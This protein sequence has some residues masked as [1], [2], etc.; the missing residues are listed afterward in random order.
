MEF[1][2]FNESEKSEWNLF[3]DS[4]PYAT[5]LQ[6]W[7]WGELKK[8]EGWQSYRVALVDSDEIILSAQCLLKKA[9]VLGNYLY[10]PYGPVFRDAQVF[11]QNLP[12]FLSELKTFAEAKGCFV[13][14]FDPLIG[15][16]V[17]E[18][19]PSE[20]LLHYLNT[21]IKKI[22]VDNGFSISKRNMQPR[23][24][25]FYDLSKTEEELLMLMKKNTRYNVRLAGKKGV[26]VTSLEISDEKMPQKID[27]YYELLLSTQERAK[28][29]P[30]R[31]KSTFTTVLEVFKNS[32]LLKYFEARFQG[33][34]ITANISQFTSYWSSSFYGASNRLHPDTKAPYLLRWESVIEAKRRGCKV[35]DFWGIILDSKQHI[36]YSETKLSFGG[37]R[38]DTYGLFALPLSNW[39]YIVWDKFLPLRNKIPFIK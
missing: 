14:E 27:E 15:K 8:S 12:H 26:E 13:I 6:F 38:M 4:T 9:P 2:E 31:P 3:V 16:L 32:N 7:E 24:K 35:Y 18:I 21:E 23:H 17:D 19:E 37:T 28:G 1:K 34:L 39:K 29:Y 10:V 36:G 25:L 30:I 5:I 22:L 20:N 11:K 33:D